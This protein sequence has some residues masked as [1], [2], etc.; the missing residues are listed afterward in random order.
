[1]TTIRQTGYKRPPNGGDRTRPFAAHRLNGGEV[2]ERSTLVSLTEVVDQGPYSS[3]VGNSS[4]NLIRGGQLVAGAPASTPLPSRWAIYW[5]ARAIAGE[6]DE[7][8]GAFIHLAFQG[9]NTFGFAPET[10]WPY[11][12]DD[13]RWRRRPPLQVMEAAFPQSVADGPRPEVDYRRI[14]STGGQRV[15]DVKRSLGAGHLVVFGTD[16]SEAFCGGELGKSGIAE[17]PGPSDKIAGGHAM[18]WCGHSPEAVRT[19]TSW[20]PGVFQGGYFDMSWDYVED[21]RTD[22]L[23]VAY[24]VPRYR[25]F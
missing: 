15:D 8:A 20:G 4:A 2:P 13:D 19:L 17:P 12:T 18:V 16:V 5:L 1:M 21:D 22:D 7:D 23:W 3:C 25:G 6:Q 24:S 9:M 10:A 14:L 11:T